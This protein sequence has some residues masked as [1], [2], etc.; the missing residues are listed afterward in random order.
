MQCTYS[1]FEIWLC[2][3]FMQPQNSWLHK[4]I[5]NASTVNF[6]LLLGSKGHLNILHAYD[7]NI[8]MLNANLGEDLNTNW[9]QFHYKIS[10]C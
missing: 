10:F 4:L 6:C 3:A 8:G 2:H 1:G 7:Q 5:H 9:Q